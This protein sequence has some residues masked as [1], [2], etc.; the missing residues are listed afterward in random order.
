MFILCFLFTVTFL[1]FRELMLLFLLYIPY[2]F[3]K[4]YRKTEIQISS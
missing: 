4:L 3:V 1:Y 2:L